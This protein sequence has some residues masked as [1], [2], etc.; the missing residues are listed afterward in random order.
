M[1]RTTESH[2]A[3]VGRPLTCHICPTGGPGVFY[4]A[5][6]CDTPGLWESA[7]AITVIE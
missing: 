2:N 6:Y 3:Q 1:H 7:K 5:A 4:A